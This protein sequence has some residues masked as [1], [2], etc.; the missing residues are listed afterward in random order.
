MA[1]DHDTRALAAFCDRVAGDRRD[2]QVQRLVGGGSCDVFALQRG[3]DRWVLRRSPR[4][5]NTAGAHDVLREYRILQAIWGQPVRV[6]RPIAACADPEVFGAPFYLMDHVPGVPIRSAIPPAWEGSPAQQAEALTELADA[7]VE[8]HSVDWSAC[9][10]TDLA[11]RPGY[12]RRQIAKWLGQ[13]ASYGGRELSGAP[14]VARWL[15]ERAPAESPQA[16]C[17]GDFKLDNALFSPALPAR[18]LAVVDWEMAGLGDPLV[19]L[20]W[21]LFFHPGP[22]GVLPLGVAGEQR[23]DRSGLPS[24]AD[25]VERY[26]Q[27]SGRDLSAIGWYDVLARWKM[28]IVLEGSYA[29]FVRGESDN[30]LHQRFGSQADTALASALD[31]IGA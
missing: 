5:A 17:H 25:L 12:L 19:D 27:R 23:F 31:L 20:S 30:P 11:H 21:M 26:A 18:L 6:A 16:L 15:E 9:G 3:T 4:R 14:E 13:L 10:L 8:I 22:G 29:K 24:T 2:L 7:L 1:E 28:A